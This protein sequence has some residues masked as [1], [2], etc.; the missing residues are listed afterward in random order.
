MNGITACAMG[1]IAKDAETRIT[2]TGKT[3]VT[4]SMAI[5]DANRAEGAP[6]EW[7][8]IVLFDVLAEG[9]APRLVKG[10]RTYAEGRARL[11]TWK[12]ADG[13]ERSGIELVAWNVQPLEQIGKRRPRPQRE[14]LAPSHEHDDIEAL[15]F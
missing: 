12:T 5:E 15:P 13:A 3:M 8:K 2:S 7:L 10:T 6:S 4:F 1:Y 11:H 9:L 14:T